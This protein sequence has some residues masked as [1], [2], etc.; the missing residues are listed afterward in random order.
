MLTVH[1]RQ[2]Y[3]GLAIS[4]IHPEFCLF[5]KTLKVK[6][7]TVMSMIELRFRLPCPH[8]AF[9]LRR[10]VPRFRMPSPVRLYATRSRTNPAVN[11]YN[12]LTED[13]AAETDASTPVPRRSKRIKL[14]DDDEVYPT[15]FP[16]GDSGSVTQESERPTKRVNVERLTNAEAEDEAVSPKRRSRSRPKAP[17]KQKPIQ[18]TLGTPHPAPEHWKEQY[19]TIKSM[20][21]RVKA[22][23][24]TMG[25]DQAQNGETDP[26]VHIRRQRLRLNDL[27]LISYRIV[28]LPL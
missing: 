26:K 4:V 14:E 21:A 15:K 9:H 19:D 17:K 27:A 24:D 16:V 10:F 28:D 18:Q 20:R 23:V 3:M 13:L 25:C 12:A 1:L 22:P 2:F 7:R 8:T 11:L 5:A 6:E